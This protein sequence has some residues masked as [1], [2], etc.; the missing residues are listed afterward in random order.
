MRL[1]EINVPHTLITF[2][3]ADHQRRIEAAWPKLMRTRLR[4][5]QARPPARP[6]LTKGGSAAPRRPMGGEDEDAPQK[7]GST[8]KQ[9]DVVLILHGSLSVYTVPKNTKRGVSFR[10]SCNFLSTVRVQIAS[11]S[12]S[13]ERHFTCTNDKKILLPKKN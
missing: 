9:T 8:P 12:K 1:T 3:P 2:L 6:P 10:D 7:T 13:R 5:T 11:A 4:M